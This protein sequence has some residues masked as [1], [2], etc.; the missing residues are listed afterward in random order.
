MEEGPKSLREA[1]ARSHGELEPD[2]LG[3]AVRAARQSLPPGE[4]FDQFSPYLTNKVDEKKK[5]RDPAW[6]RR[7]AVIAALGG[8]YI[9][10]WRGQD[11]E[12]PPL[13]PRWLDAAVKLRHLGLVNAVGRPGH[14]GA[15]AFLQEEFD[16]LFK[17][18][19]S[20]EQMN[21]VLTVLVRHKHPKATDDLLA[22]YEKTIGK[23]GVYT[24][25]YYHLF[26]ELPK[27][28]VPK[29]EALVPRL[30]GTEADGFVGVIEELRNKKD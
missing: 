15:E 1:L 4:V 27:S 21:D 13:D 8:E 10:W 9:S 17:K 28:A 19:K 26:P 24:F 30:K 2:A 14:P 18:A 20:Q 23:P 16:A 5:A 25:W 3:A 12:A 22:S 11:D 6:A 7:E 29:L